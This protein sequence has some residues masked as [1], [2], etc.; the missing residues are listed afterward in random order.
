MQWQTHALIRV[1]TVWQTS[2]AVHDRWPECDSA[3]ARAQAS[4]I[5]VHTRPLAPFG[6][7][8]EADPHRTEVNILRFFA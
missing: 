6:R 3:K 4:R 7:L 2:A 1:D 8:G 5:I